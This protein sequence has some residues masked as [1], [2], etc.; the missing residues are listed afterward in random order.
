MTGNNSTTC[1][2]VVLLLPTPGIRTRHNLDV[3]GGPKKLSPVVSQ[4][5]GNHNPILPFQSNQRWKLAQIVG[6]GVTLMLIEQRIHVHV[7][8]PAVLLGV[9]ARN[10]ANA[11]H[12]T[13]ARSDLL[14]RA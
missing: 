1:F 13:Q 14:G 11:S 10:S 9:Q 6:N 7:I 2:E 8:E 5:S 12:R 3:N 4:G